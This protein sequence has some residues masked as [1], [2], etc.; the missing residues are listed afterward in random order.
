MKEA[1]IIWL[2]PEPRSLQGITPASQ[3]PRKFQQ[4]FKTGINLRHKINWLLM[5]YPRKKVSIQQIPIVT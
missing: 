1:E 3:T 5:F 2:K 4:G